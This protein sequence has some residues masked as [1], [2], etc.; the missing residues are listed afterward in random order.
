[1]T[2]SNKLSPAWLLAALLALAPLAGLSTATF[3]QNLVQNNYYWYVPE[4]E[5][6]SPTTFYAEPRFD[7]RQIRLTRTERFKLID[8]I[9]GGW[10]ILE[11]D[12]AGKAYIHQRL[13][14][15]MVYNPAASDTW[16]EF[17]RASVFEEAPGRV[18]ARLTAQPSIQAPKATDGKAPSWRNYKDSW[19]VRPG[20][21]STSGLAQNPENPEAGFQSRPAEKKPRP[22][23]S[24]LPPIGSEPQP[25]PGNA[26]ETPNPQAY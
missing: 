7:T 13:L 25:E 22:R 26:A 16:Y 5:K 19:N 1:M 23:H 20:R 9:K 21:G 11:F 14:R 24:L 6:Y 17:K 8:G 10:F 15:S 18:E 2:N 4:H 12:V 3:A